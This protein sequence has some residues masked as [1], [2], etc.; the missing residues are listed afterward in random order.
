MELESQLQRDEL[1]PKRYPSDPVFVQNDPLFK[2][3]TESLV[4][5]ELKQKS[6]HSE[7]ILV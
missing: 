2:I 1:Q 6:C 7:P 3:E 5:G 4:Q